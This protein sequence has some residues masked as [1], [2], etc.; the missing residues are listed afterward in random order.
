MFDLDT[1]GMP[2]VS[3]TITAFSFASR[4]ATDAPTALKQ[5]VSAVFATIDR[6]ILR[7]ASVQILN[8]YKEPL[9]QLRR[10]H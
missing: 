10:A 8:P 4:F 7:G 5:A 2:S 1:F 9:R 3:T 6:H